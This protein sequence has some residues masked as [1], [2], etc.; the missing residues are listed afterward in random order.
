MDLHG[1]RDYFPQGTI[2]WK[3]QATNQENT[4]ALAVPYIDARA[5]AWRLDKVCGPGNW[6]DQYMSQTVKGKECMVCA[7]SIHVGDEWVTKYGYGEGSD[8]KSLE[9]DSFKRATG[10]LRHLME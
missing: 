1:L 3:A 5:V 7:L 4:K 2:K 10:K 9:S 8:P 6:R